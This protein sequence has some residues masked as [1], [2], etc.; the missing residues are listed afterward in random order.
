MQAAGIPA[1]FFMLAFNYIFGADFKN[2]T[3]LLQQAMQAAGIP[4]KYF[5]LAFNCIFGADFKNVTHLLQQAMQASLFFFE[6]AVS[7]P[8]IFNY[9]N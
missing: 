4:A 6:K 9:L 8:L 5:M 3:H 2:A 7:N 1:K